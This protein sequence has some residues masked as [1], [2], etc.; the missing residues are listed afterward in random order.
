MRKE[1]FLAL[2]EGPLSVRT[3]SCSYHVMHPRMLIHMLRG[4]TVSE[5]SGG[6]LSLPADEP[7]FPYLPAFDRRTNDDQKEAP[8][9]GGHETQ[10]WWISGRE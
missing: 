6:P 7:H 2:K 8:R 9:D 4:S 1:E 3:S 5:R 10:D